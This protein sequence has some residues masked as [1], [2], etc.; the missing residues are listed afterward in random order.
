[1]L[2]NSRRV[3]RWCFF[4]FHWYVIFAATNSEESANEV[5]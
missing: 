3:L 4:M 1:M 2:S 5:E